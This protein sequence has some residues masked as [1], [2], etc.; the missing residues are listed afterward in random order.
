VEQRRRSRI[1]RIREVSASIRR[2]ETVAL[3]GDGQELV[4]IHPWLVRLVLA[5]DGELHEE[6]AY[7]NPASKTT[8]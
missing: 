7:E 3:L 8:D 4:R 6:I 2:I 1:G 5:V